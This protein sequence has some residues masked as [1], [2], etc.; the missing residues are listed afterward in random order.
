M[1]GSQPTLA[2]DSNGKWH[3]SEDRKFPV[4]GGWPCQK[5]DPS[6]KKRAQ[7]L[8]KIFAREVALPKCCSLPRKQKGSLVRLVKYLKKCVDDPTQLSG[9]DVGMIRLL[10]ACSIAKRGPP[11]SERC[12]IYRFNQQKHVK[13]PTFEEISQ[14]LKSRLF[15]YPRDD[16]IERIEEV[17]QLVSP[18]ESELWEFEKGMAIPEALKRKIQRAR[19]GTVEQLIAG[20]LISSSETLA[21]FL[22]HIT[23]NVITEV[24]Q[25]M[26]LRRLYLSMYNA[27]RKRRSLLLLN[28]EKQVR[29][30]ELPWIEALRSYVKNLSNNSGRSHS[31]D[32]QYLVR[33]TMVQVVQLTLKTFPHV[34]IP[35]PMIEELVTLS[36]ESE[37]GLPLTKEVAA[38]IYMGDFSS[39]FVKAAQTS[40]ILLHDSL[41]ES[42]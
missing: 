35:N 41:Y 5:Y 11:N 14:L 31:L 7:H 3:L 28:Y 30:E 36:K 10:I 38:D 1:E 8:L 25:D 32:Y 23:A 6:W 29:L 42:Y 9:R 2:T 27:F 19:K 40:S 33:Q 17:V 24:L 18:E 21:S 20:G 4:I 37:M 13:G 39:T 34:I 22:P 16:G 26:N 12:Q 15:D